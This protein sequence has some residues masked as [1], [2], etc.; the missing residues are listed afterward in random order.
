MSQILNTKLRTDLDVP[1]A[2]KDE[3]KRLGARWDSNQ[4]VW[5]VPESVDLV[6]FEKWIPKPPDINIRTE[7]YYILESS[8]ACWKCGSPT[9]VFALAMP[10]GHE[11]LEPI[12][13]DDMEFE[14]DEAYESWLNSSESSEWQAADMRAS[15]HYVEYVSRTVEARLRALTPHFRPDFSQTTQSTY[16]MNHC[17]SCG[18]KQGDFEMHCEPQGA[19]MPLYPEDATRTVLHHVGEP[20]E[21]FYGG[22]SYDLEFFDLMQRV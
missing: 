3:A 18:M 12:E 17:T 14:S 10:V 6:P 2:Q 4:R 16:W 20:F 8:K 11:L 5:Y 7:H 15:I 1:Y 13:D 21:A 9:R 22:Y 19:F